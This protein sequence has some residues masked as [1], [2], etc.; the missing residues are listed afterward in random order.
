MYNATPKDIA[1]LRESG[2]IAA[3]A[4][5]LCVQAAQPGISTH[6]LDMIARK[7]LTDAGSKIPFLDYHGY[8]AAI[9]TSINDHLVHGL[10]TK[11][12]ILKEGDIVG[13]DI[14]ADIDGYITDMAV[15]I[16][17]G[18]VPAE[19][20][21][22]MKVTQEALRLAIRSVRPGMTTGDLGALI[23]DYIEKFHYGVVRDLVGHGVGRE[24]HEEPMI[25]NFGVR[26]QGSILEEN[27]VI[28]IEPMVTIGDWHVKTLSDKW[29]I[30]TLDGSLGAHFEHTLVV[31]K[32]GGDVV[33]QTNDHDPWP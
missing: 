27:M 25:P 2:R 14:G 26:G 3:E 8:P 19:S 32:H 16:P 33:T 12:A 5:Q 10:P 23:Q 20:T 4:L 22:L 30:A 13:I 11:K 31:T 9:C 1:G 24:L 18:K 6:E 28:A 7:S 15:T 17:V 21:K 29:T